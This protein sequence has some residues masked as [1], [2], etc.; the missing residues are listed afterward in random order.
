[1]TGRR[2][3]DVPWVVP[4]R[5]WTSPASREN[6]SDVY[7]QHRCWVPGLTF[8][9]SVSF[10]MLINVLFKVTC[11]GVPYLLCCSSI[12][13]LWSL[14]I[15]CICCVY[16]LQQ[17]DWPYMLPLPAS[18]SLANKEGR[19]QPEKK[20]RLGISGTVGRRVRIW[21][22]VRMDEK[23]MFYRGVVAAGWSNSRFQAERV[24]IV[25]SVSLMLSY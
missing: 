18:Y 8:N 17:I 4:G 24:I 21:R 10:L 16:F 15:C 9:R 12:G 6:V 11:W 3:T 5:A 20:G 1:M 7:R 14:C 25:K 22:R 2:Q 13:L 19:K 23:Q